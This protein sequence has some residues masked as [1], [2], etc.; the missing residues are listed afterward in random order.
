VEL[1]ETD[2]QELEFMFVLKK[3]ITCSLNVTNKTDSYVA[4]NLKT[5]QPKKYIVQPNK[6]ILFPRAKRTVIITMDRQTTAPPDFVCSDKFLLL[7]TI[8]IEGFSTED[9]D[10]DTFSEGTGKVVNELKLMVV[11]VA[12]SQSP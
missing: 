3:R 1:L 2:R 8:V 10:E 9:I 4:F 11:Y 5:T 7:S 6:C 12:P